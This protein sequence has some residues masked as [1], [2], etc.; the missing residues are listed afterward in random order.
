MQTNL[1]RTS[2]IF[3]F[4]LGAASLA[5]AAEPGW[6]KLT[7]QEKGYT[8]P[9]V[10]VNIPL[11]LL[12]VIADAVNTEDLKVDLA[13]DEIKKEGVDIKKLWDGV[14][15]L[16][17]T[18]FIEIDDKDEHVKVWKDAKDF[19]ITVTKKGSPEPEVLVTFPTAIVDSVVGDGTQPITFKRIVLELKKAGPMQFVEV[20]DD[21]EHVK[22]WIE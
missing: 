22:I 16:G 11:S 12:D 5:V 1:A 6:L 4:I 14:K 3:P 2:L 21:D 13:L 20:H 17:P 7:V 18:D 15:N 8:E 19:K 10:K 9:N